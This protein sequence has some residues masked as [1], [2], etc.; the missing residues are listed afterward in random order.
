MLIANRLLRWLTV[1]YR[2]APESRDF[3]QGV[4]TQLREGL[5]VR[6]AV[7]NG[8]DSRTFFGV[9]LDRRGI[10][11]VWIQIVNR[12]D[13]AYRLQFVSID[14]NYFSPLEAARTP[15]RRRV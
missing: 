2:P 12:T 15:D 14:P 4:V 5:E 6:V 3:L 1:P 8:H 7:L 11:P 9:P 13:R 10:Q